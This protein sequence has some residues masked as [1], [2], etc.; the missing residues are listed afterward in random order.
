MQITKRLASSYLKKEVANSLVFWIPE[1]GFLDYITL[2]SQRIQVTM[3]YTSAKIEAGK[4]IL[5]F[6]FQ[7][8]S[9]IREKHNNQIYALMRFGSSLTVDLDHFINASL[10]ACLSANQRIWFFRL[11]IWGRE[12]E[13]NGHGGCMKYGRLCL[14]REFVIPLCHGFPSLA[15]TTIIETLSKEITN[16]V[17]HIS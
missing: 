8:E 14:I 3:F 12:L 5:V 15:S 11:L 6:S 16:L 9:I 4:D 13:E 7:K 2:L 1:C 17:H 10:R